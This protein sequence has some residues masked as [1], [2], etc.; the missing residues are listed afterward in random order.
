MNRGK[1]ILCMARSLELEPLSIST[2]RVYHS[3]KDA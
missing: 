3:G 2:Y 1:M